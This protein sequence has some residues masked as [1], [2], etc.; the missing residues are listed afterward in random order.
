MIIRRI[1]SVFCFARRLC[2]RGAQFGAATL[3]VLA[4]SVA[5]AAQSLDQSPEGQGI[6]SDRLVIGPGKVRFAQTR[7]GA[8]QEIVPAWAN[9]SN[10]ISGGGF[11][12]YA[13]DADGRIVELIATGDAT[14]DVPAAA[15]DLGKCCEGMAHGWRA[16]SLDPDDDGDGRADEDRLDGIDND[17]DGKIDEDFAAIGDE[18]IVTEY[19]MREPATGLAIGFHQEA[20]AWSLPNIDGAILLSLRV[21]NAGEKP[22]KN[23]RVVAYYERKGAFALTERTIKTATNQT[24]ENANRSSVVVVSSDGRGANLALVG[25]VAGI[26]EGSGWISGHV[27]SRENM[28]R[29]VA[30]VIVAARDGGE[31]RAESAQESMESRMGPVS[32]GA[33]VYHISPRLDRL[34]PGQTIDLNLAIVVAPQLTQI[35]GSTTLAVETYFGDGTNL[36]VPPPV[37]MTPRVLWARYRMD[38][39]EEEPTLLISIQDSG[40]DPVGPGNISYV[41]GVAP[42]DVKPR[43]IPS[44]GSV[45]SLRGNIADSI[46]MDKSR[47]TLKGRLDTGEFFEMILRPE[48]PVKPVPSREAEAYWQTPGK[49][50]RELLTGSPNPFRNATTIS[51]EVPSLIEQEDGS[52]LPSSGARDTTVKIYNVSGRLVNILVEDHLSPGTYSIGWA[53]VDE[54]G[55]DV[56]SGVY[57]LRLQ[58]QQRS[59]TQRLILLK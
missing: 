12:L 52:I 54:S 7:N 14:L 41:T 26:D 37:S 2:S 23:V 59:T 20:Y 45:L 48:A 32:D 17:H 46:V 30:Q 36:Y 51:Y 29:S 21:S 25:S 1:A 33:V 19:S 24:N 40:D 42:S 50:S 6:H 4:V 5:F 18:M 10:L 57:Y 22:L 49:L 55:N 28:E 13:E 39:A 53:A 35:E 47:A 16:P 34:E 44:G 27:E 9:G 56:A 38:E 15:R 3:A 58:I 43:N 31:N 11:A 8:W